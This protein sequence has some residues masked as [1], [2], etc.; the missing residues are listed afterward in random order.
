MTAY[1]QFAYE[2]G[3][4]PQTHPQRLQAVAKLFG[5][6][7]PALETCSVLELGCGD[8]ANLIP[9]AAHLPQARFVGVDLAESPIAKGAHRIARLGLNNVR[10]LQADVSA[11]GDSLGKFDY[12]IAH[13]LYSWV[14]EFVRDAILKLV[15]VSLS[16]QGVAYI[17]YNALPGCRLRHLVREMLQFRFGARACEIE[18]IPEA[19]A[20]LAAYAGLSV[21]ANDHTSN[22]EMPKIPYL[23]TLKGEIQFSLALPD[24]VMFHDD[25]SEFATPFYLHEFARAAQQHG[26]Q[27]LGEPGVET[28]FP[29]AG[30]ESFKIAASAWTPLNTDEWLAQQQYLDFALGRRFKQSLLCKN[31]QREGDLAPIPRLERK[32]GANTISGMHIRSALQSEATQSQVSLCNRD[33]VKF[34]YLSRVVSVD[35]PIAKVSL[36]HLSDAFPNTVPVTDLIH[37]SL[38]KC[39][40]HGLSYPNDATI[41]TMTRLLWSLVLSGH[42]EIFG[43]AIR[44][45]CLFT[46]PEHEGL[47][48]SQEIESMR[49]RLS[50]FVAD[51]I[52]ENLP[53]AGGLHAEVR[54][55]D[56]F[57]RAL[58]LQMDG[59]KT[60]RQLA[61]F[62]AKT[63]DGAGGLARMVQFVRFLDRQGAL[64]RPA[65][66]ES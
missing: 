55:E 66:G 5:L 42:V 16:D 15:Q 13:G 25:L 46:P 65:P 32:V 20:F 35:E 44:I 26:L 53:M 11:L 28:M 19:R 43:Q 29:K 2:G 7:A 51:A 58:A 61:D 17:S 8:G 60:I 9:M 63:G 27:Y 57:S 3:V 48:P 49:P 40:A 38:A 18:T 37:S 54:L 64:V 47:R 36:Q 21:A 62:A 22:Q 56:R 59:L 34:A 33:L 23:D 30:S 10:L 12:I 6:E 14:P 45:R 41:Q 4:F 39:Q 50:P 52:A 1:D 31:L 24:Y